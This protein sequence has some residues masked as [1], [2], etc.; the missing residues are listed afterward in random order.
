MRIV[1]SSS[2]ERK[3]LA[4]R[5]AV[6]KRHGAYESVLELGGMVKGSNI[7]ITD[8]LIPKAWIGYANFRVEDKDLSACWSGAGKSLNP[9]GDMHYH[10]E[11]SG[12]SQSYGGPQPSLVDEANSLRQA[13]L[14]HIFNL[15]E[16]VFKRLLKPGS[17][18]GNGEFRPYPLNPYLSVHIPQ[19]EA[20]PGRFPYLTAR[21]KTSLWAS[22]IAPRDGN[23][24]LIAASV[25]EHVYSASNPEEPAIVAHEKVPVTILSDEEVARL[26]GWPLERIRLEINREQLE[27]EVAAKYRTDYG[28]YGYSYYGYDDRGTYWSDRYD[29]SASWKRSHRSKV[30]RITWGRDL[31]ESRYLGKGSSKADVAKLL[32]ELASWVDGERDKKGDLSF[33]GR[34]AGYD[35]VLRALRECSRCI[36][37]QGARGMKD[38]P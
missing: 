21:K 1:L 30:R 11:G 31:E 8:G 10:P 32:R 26:T 38:E 22:L 3:Q 2:F 15:Q 6:L 14:Y 9:V 29:E 16:Q 37:E 7:V 4:I 18:E 28:S 36:E 27:K 13:S 20:T 24:A 23:S 35:E 34:E 25:I 33:L 19:T 5:E 17:E 12:S